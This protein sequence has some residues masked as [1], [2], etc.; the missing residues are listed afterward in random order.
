ME[1]LFNFKYLIKK[2]KQIPNLS[3]VTENSSDGGLY[4]Y[5]IFL[6]LIL[7]FINNPI[8]YSVIGIKARKQTKHHLFG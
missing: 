8:N 4:R 2:H 3:I 7:L 6:L 1:E 5:N